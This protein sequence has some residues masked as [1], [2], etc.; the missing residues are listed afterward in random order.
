MSYKYFYVC[1]Y[2]VCLNCERKAVGKENGRP[3]ED[4]GELKKEVNLF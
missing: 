3:S 2:G 1:V 4:A